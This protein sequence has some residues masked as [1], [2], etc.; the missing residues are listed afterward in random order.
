MSVSA[1]YI[2]DIMVNSLPYKV[3][4]MISSYSILHAIGSK[5]TLYGYLEQKAMVEC[6]DLYTVLLSGMIK[7][8]VFGDNLLIPWS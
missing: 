4:F 5:G 7:I 6:K 8:L 1:L 2:C 3:Y